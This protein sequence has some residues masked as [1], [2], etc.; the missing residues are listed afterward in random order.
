MRLFW[1]SNAFL[2][3]LAGC[4]GPAGAVDSPRD[5][6]GQTRKL[7]IAKCARCHR[8]YDPT[9]YT[10]SAWQVWMDKMSKKAKLK[11]DQKELLTRYLETVRKGRIGEAPPSRGPADPLEFKH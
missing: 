3:A 8:L 11:V 4:S 5:E 6:V 10:D 9:Q 2:L 1:L 7:Y